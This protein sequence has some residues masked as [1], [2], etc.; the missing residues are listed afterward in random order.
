MLCGQGP[1]PAGATIAHFRDLGLD[2]IPGSGLLAAAVP[3][4]HR[5]LA[6]AAARPRHG[7]AAR[8]ARARDPLRRDGHPGAAADRGDHRPGGRPVPRAVAHLGRSV[9]LGARR[10][11]AQPGL[12][13]RPCERLRATRPRPPAATA[14]RRSS[15]RCDSWQR[16]FVAAQID[17]FARTP[18]WDSSG[19]RHAGVL[20]GR[21]PGRLG[22]RPTRRPAT[23]DF[24][25]LTVCKTGPWGQGPVLLQQ[26]ALLDGLRPHAG[27]APTS[28][29]PSSSAPS[30]PSPT[31][32]RGTATRA[33]VP[34]DALLSP[35]YA[36]DR[37]TL[38][39]DD[40]RRPAAPGHAGRARPRRC[41][42]S[43]L[44]AAERGR[45]AGRVRPDDVR[46][47]GVAHR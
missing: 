41:P 3:G 25:G 34:L 14:R 8:G 46:A 27:H 37:R 7:D 28:S 12:G 29:T 4:Q 30:S 36:D 13:R 39:G 44:T 17:A 10:L 19:E 22:A 6:D 33:E 9:Y 31:A 2:L 20:T 15:T 1:A 26:L 38:V 16:G 24:G 5:G 21:G 11:A 42:I 40:G 32:R 43:S 47:D 35:D 45:V 23:L 18:L